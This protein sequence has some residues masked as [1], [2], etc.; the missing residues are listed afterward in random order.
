ME[1]INPY[2]FLNKHI[3]ITDTTDLVGLKNIYSITRNPPNILRYNNE[4]KQNIM[5]IFNL[6]SKMFEK[7]TVN[8][9][10]HIVKINKKD[11]NGFFRIIN[12]Y[13]LWGYG[14]YHF[15]TEVL[16][17][18]LEISKPY[19][20]Y[21]MHSKFAQN[22]F[23]WFNIKNKICFEKPTFENV[24]ESFEQQ[25]IEC[26]YPSPQKISLIRDIVLKKV[27]FTRKKG[28]LIY[29]REAIRRILNNS[30]VLD[31]L[32]RIFPSIDWIVF[33]VLP[34]SDTVELF[35]SASIIVAPH[36]AGLTNMLFSDS[37]INIIEF[38]PLQNPNP[39]YWHLSELM[40]N[41]YCMIPCITE[42]G[43]FNIDI[44]NVEQIISSYAK[45]HNIQ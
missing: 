27:S 31:M 25:Y 6:S 17:S 32:K 14:Y 5:N 13:T 15:L 10:K 36:G 43:N 18:V 12:A 28:I 16:P 37:G 35:S 1:Y 42:N 24:K 39:C 11:P 44:P 7:H 33:D 19:T 9:A 21:T 29:R 23:Q 34:F 3:H 45:E 4:V 20:I 8:F 26:G 38:M 41:K 40:K 22:V 30:D 2:H